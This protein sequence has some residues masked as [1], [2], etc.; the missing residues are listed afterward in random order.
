MRRTLRARSRIER[1]EARGPPLAPRRPGQVVT[2]GEA[3]RRALAAHKHALRFRAVRSFS[4]YAASRFGGLLD[5]GGA[6]R[7]DVTSRLFNRFRK[8]E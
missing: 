4:F 1:G 3:R 6:V 8:D 7:R 5:G 2:P